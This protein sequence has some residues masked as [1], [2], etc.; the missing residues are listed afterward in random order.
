MQKRLS[1]WPRSE[2]VSPALAPDAVKDAWRGQAVA[3]DAV[4]A[5][6]QHWSSCNHVAG[7]CLILSDCSVPLRRHSAAAVAA[8][9]AA[10]AEEDLHGVAVQQVGTILGDWGFS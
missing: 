10:A 5:A 9:R 2:E 1:S 7:A 8:L 3:C 4:T 6:W